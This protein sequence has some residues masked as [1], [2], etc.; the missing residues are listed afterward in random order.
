MGLSSSLLAAL[1]S[2]AV[3]TGPSGRAGADVSARPL[4]D[5]GVSPWVVTVPEDAPRPMRYAAEEFTNFI[6]R[7][8]GAHIGIISPDRAQKLNVVRIEAPFGD[9]L[10]D[11]FS[12][13]TA[14]G[15]IVLRGNDIFGITH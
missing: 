5:A 10:K 6:F 11:E 9:R 1:V 12:V 14:P 3:C 8:S 13:Q 7:I 15:E 2:S 4:F